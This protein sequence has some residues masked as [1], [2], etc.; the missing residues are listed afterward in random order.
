MQER[1][2]YDNE[3]RAEHC[4]YKASSAQDYQGEPLE[5]GERPGMDSLSQSPEGTNP[6]H[7]LVWVL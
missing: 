4:I 7:T 5:A 3:G 1:K 6:T 2:P